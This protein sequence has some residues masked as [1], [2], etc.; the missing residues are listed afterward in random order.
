MLVYTY[1][2][3]IGEEQS[4]TREE[5]EEELKHPHVIKIVRLDYGIP[6]LIQTQPGKSGFV[7]TWGLVSIKWEGDPS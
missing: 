3:D 7:S 5:L 1:W 6:T 2:C 4:F